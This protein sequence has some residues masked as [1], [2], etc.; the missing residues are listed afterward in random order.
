M[1]TVQKADRILLLEG[2][3]IIESGTH[4]ELMDQDREYAKLYRKQFTS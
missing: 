2:G 1:S 3:R 4:G